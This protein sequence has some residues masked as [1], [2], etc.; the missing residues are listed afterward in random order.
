MAKKEEE[1][2]IAVSY[3]TAPDTDGYFIE[4]ADDAELE[5][6]TKVH[7]NGNKVKK[8]KLPSC[9]KEAIVRELTGKDTKEIT[10]F[11]GKDTERYQMASITVAT[12]IDGVKQPIEIF[13]SMKLKDLNRILS[14]HSDLNF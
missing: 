3:P 7:T 6:F 11:M 4:T 12:T 8:V 2:E 9:G 13:E 10:R 14:I 5:I 1:K